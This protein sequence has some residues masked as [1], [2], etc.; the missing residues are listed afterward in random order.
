MSVIQDLRGNL[1]MTGKLDEISRVIGKVETHTETILR[2]VAQLKADMAA[3]ID[4]AHWVETEGKPAVKAMKRAKHIAMG[5][6]GVAGLGSS[7]SWLPKVTA[8]FHAVFP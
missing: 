6:L 5:A 8:I 7:P 4:A 3:S 1:S 2:D